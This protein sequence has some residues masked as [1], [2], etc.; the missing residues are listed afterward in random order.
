MPILS[1]DLSAALNDKVV[2]EA[3]RLVLSN[4]PSLL[5]VVG[6]GGT[7]LAY[8]GYKMSW[9]DMP[10]D[11]DAFTVAADA[12]DTATSITINSGAVTA[13]AGMLLS[14]SS[15]DEIMLVTAVSGTTLTVTRGVAGTAAAITTGAVLTVDSVG[16]E[17]NSTGSEDGIYQPETVENYFQTI[18][19]MVTMSRRAMATAQF[20]NTNSM[21]FQIQNRIQQLAIKLDRMLIRGV[22]LNA[23]VDSNDV[24]YSGGLRYWAQQTGRI[25]E[26]AAGAALTLDLIN[27]L[28]QEVVTRGGTT[29]TIVVGIEKARQISALIAANYSSQ[30]L[31]DWTA[32]EGSVLMLPSDLPVV[33]N[34]NKI[35]VDTN[36]AGDELFILD[37]SMTK[38]IPMSSGNADADGNW[39]SLDA[40]QKGQD[41]QSVRIVGDMG[42]EIMNSK[43]HFARLSGLA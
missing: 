9:L 21:A 34:V 25:N 19:T 36:V 28:N 35:V 20:G 41:G 27:D 24:T 12:T 1:G 37:S 7:R 33:G 8:D 32:D 42:I 13:R 29:D 3:F 38:V 2:N 4:R 15:S 6:F 16:R 5:G 30:R 31:A 23:S 18:D 43:T 26:A 17:E 11:A 39:R 14:V 40:T 22:K 10:V